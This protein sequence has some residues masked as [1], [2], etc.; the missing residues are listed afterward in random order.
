[1]TETTTSMIT[2]C[3]NNASIFETK[4]LI[5]IFSVIAVITGWFVNGYLNRKN[6]IAKKR[7]DHR[8]PTLK[9]FVKV[10]YFIQKNSA[11]FTDPQFLILV[12]EARGDFQ[13]YG[14]SDEIELFE[15]FIK[16]Y[17]IQNLQGANKALAELVPLV[18]KRIRMELDI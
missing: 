8:L 17:E 12:E 7:L 2:L 4:D 1:M 18:R 11:P 14:K 15:E 16:S 6:E 3:C 13:L 9:S 5:T 10:W